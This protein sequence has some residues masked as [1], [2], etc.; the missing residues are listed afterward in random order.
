MSCMTKIVSGVWCC[1]GHN[2]VTA[3][4][5]SSACSAPFFNYVSLVSSVV[6]IEDF[7]FPGVVDW[8]RRV[9]FQWFFCD[10]ASGMRKMRL[11]VTLVILS[12]LFANTS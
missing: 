6:S 10:I 2:I 12:Y 11:G 7:P 1:W 3:V 5:G 8:K 4:R 9:V